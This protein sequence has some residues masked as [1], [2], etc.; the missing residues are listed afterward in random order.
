M[1]VSPG[2]GV[3]GGPEAPVQSW[4]ASLLQP[5][6]L[7]AAALILLVLGILSGRLVT[8]RLSRGLGQPKARGARL[9]PGHVWLFWPAGKSVAEKTRSV[10]LSLL[11]G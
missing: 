2:L 11:T 6:L 10:V 7:R 4:A 9:S 3:I 8:I 1:W 5:S